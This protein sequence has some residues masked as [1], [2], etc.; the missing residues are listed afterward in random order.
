MRREGRK[1]G[2]Y[3][4]VRMRIHRQGCQKFRL[5]AHVVV[6]NKKRALKKPAKFNKS[7]HLN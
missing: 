4:N 5:L 7:S 3:Q 6:P 2:M 1:E